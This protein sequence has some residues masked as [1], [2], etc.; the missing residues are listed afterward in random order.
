MPQVQY[1][2]GSPEQIL[3]S[4]REFRVRSMPRDKYFT[5]EDGYM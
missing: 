1:S 5:A 2:A 3:V 4:N